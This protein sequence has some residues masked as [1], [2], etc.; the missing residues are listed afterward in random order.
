MGRLATP[1]IFLPAHAVITETTTS[2]VMKELL[3][4]LLGSEKKEIG[5]NFQLLKIL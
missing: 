2:A 3:C 4:I 1:F 5:F